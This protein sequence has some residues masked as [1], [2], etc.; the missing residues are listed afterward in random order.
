MD[1]PSTSMGALN[2][3]FA[4]IERKCDD[5]E[6]EENSYNHFDDMYAIR[7]FYANSVVNLSTYKYY[8]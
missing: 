7:N 3:Y 6:K 4:R 5:Y 2:D 1:L 8:R